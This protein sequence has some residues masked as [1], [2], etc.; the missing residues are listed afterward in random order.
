MNP[1]RRQLLRD[2]TSWLALCSVGLDAYA[3]SPIPSAG[4]I[5]IAD[6]HSHLGILERSKFPAD[7]ASDMR[8]FRVALVSWKLVS[9]APWLRST[10]TGIEQRAQPTPAELWSYFETGFKRML[11]YAQQTGLELIKGKSDIERALAAQPFI[12]MASEGADFLGGD[13][14]LLDKAFKMGLRHLQLVHYIR[15]PVG[16]FSTEA[17]IHGGLSAMGKNL[18]S[19][20][21]EL[22]ILVDLAHCSEAAIEDALDVAKKPLVWSHGW[23]EGSGGSYR[24]RFGFQRRRLSI[25]QAKQISAK[26]GIV[27]L[28]GFALDRPIS[29]WNVALQDH[30]GYARELEKLANLLGADSV[31]LGTDLAGVGDNWSVAN[32]RDVREVIAALE[33]SMPKESVEKIAALNF[34]RVLKAVLPSS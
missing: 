6:M 33:R 17:P 19:A 20:C 29:G 7:L 2:L 25:A 3:Q 9:D 10:F 8:N 28:W 13:I 32:Y 5:P 34:A 22:G 11:A 27:G 23:V 21:E 30:T 18:I 24:D 15:S 4:S 26:G 14:S 12:I 31:A 16:D 1:S